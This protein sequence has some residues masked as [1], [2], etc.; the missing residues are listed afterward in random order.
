MRVLSDDPYAASFPPLSNLLQDCYAH[1]GGLTHPQG[2]QEY[3]AIAATILRQNAKR[4]DVAFDGLE[5]KVHI[6]TKGVQAPPTSVWA[7]IEEYPL[8]E[9]QSGVRLREKATGRKI[10][11]YANDEG[12]LL[13]FLSSPKFSGVDMFMSN[14]Y[15]RDGLDDYVLV[16]GGTTTDSHDVVLYND[17]AQLT[18]LLGP[19]PDTA[20]R[21]A[22]RAMTEEPAADAHSRTARAHFEKSRYREAILSARLA[23]ETGCGGR[24]RDVKRRLE[25]APEDIRNA[26]EA[27]YLIRHVAVHEGD[28]RVEQHEA[29]D[30]IH[31]MRQVLDYLREPS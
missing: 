13:T 4:I 31:A 11:M 7:Y 1:G 15:E 3:V 17:D 12:H 2:R 26:A 10:E 22:F 6:V 14:L 23:V 28:T 16:S 25:G 8:S 5:T 9:G 18:Y 21:D 19:T 24:G 29:A 27:L 20:Y 30:A